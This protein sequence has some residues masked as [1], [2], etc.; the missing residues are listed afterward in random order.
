MQRLILTR[1]PASF[2]PRSQQEQVLCGLRCSEVMVAQRH[3]GGEHRL[4]QPLQQTEVR[5]ASS[6]VVLGEAGA[7]RAG[8]VPGTR[9]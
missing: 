2:P 7:L 6:S 8:P 9:P 4:R 3:R 1:P 5:A